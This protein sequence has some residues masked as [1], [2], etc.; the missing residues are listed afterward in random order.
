[1]SGL[2]EFLTPEITGLAVAALVMLAVGGIIYS[3]FQPALSGSKRRDQRVNAVAARPQ[4]E[5]QRKALRD[6]DRRKRSIQ[7]QLKEFEV[8]QKAKQDKQQKVSLKVKIEQAGLA[9]ETHH[10][11]IFSIVAGLV[12]LILGLIFSG[13]L[14]IAAAFGFAGTLG[15]PRWYVSSKRKRR[16]NAFLDELPNGVDIIVRGVKAGLPLSDCIKVVARE[17]REPVATEFRKITETQIMGISLAEAVGKLPERVP[18]AEANFFAIVV[19][20]QQKA[21]GGLA[22]ALNNLSKVLRGRKAMKRKI[23][24]L[25]A[26]AKSSAGIIGSLPFFVGGIMYLI[27]PSYI[28]VLFETTA[29]NIIIAGCLFWMFCGIMVMRAMINFDF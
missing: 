29:G 14:L 26:E 3:L 4:S 21:G 20:I 2:E 10:F 5:N 6:V 1:M 11:V 18:L 13:N 15:F 12:F 17:A 28:L 16:F 9:W 22:E 19:A 7:D 25:S 23:K 27:S 8:R 24:A